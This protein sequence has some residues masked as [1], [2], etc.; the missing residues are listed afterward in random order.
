MLKLKKL[1]KRFFD[2]IFS[3]ILLVIL[4]P[5]LLIIAIT[6]KL[7]SKGPI[8][9]KQN[10]IGYK[11]KIFEIYKFRSLFSRKSEEVNQ[12]NESIVNSKNDKRVTKIGSF[13]RRSSLDELPQLIN[14]LKGEMSFIGP[15]PILPEQY[16]VVPVKYINRFNVLPGITGLSQIKGRRNL[17][18]EDQLI[19]DC[20]Y[21][22][23]F[24]LIFDLYIVFK[25]I[26][27]VL[28]KEGIDGHTAKNWREYIGIWDNK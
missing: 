21:Y 8:F 15:R 9:F 14:I 23:K 28:R 17:D 19:Y 25:T 22:D 7:D 4:F 6:I 18:W 26:L 11:K 12:L 20:E 27:V 24:N 5:I 2:I 13:L 1:L 10:R 16:K 3:A